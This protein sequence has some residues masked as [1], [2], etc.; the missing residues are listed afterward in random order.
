MTSQQMFGTMESVV[1]RAGR[2]G[3]A[4]VGSVGAGGTSGGFP[5][6]TSASVLGTHLRTYGW[7]ADS[8]VTECMNAC[9][10]DFTPLERRHH[11]R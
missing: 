11:C 7:V 2:S 4:H 8:A 6:A 9:G 3:S 5:V 1:S 10:T